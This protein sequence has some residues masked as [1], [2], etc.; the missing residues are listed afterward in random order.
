MKFFTLKQLLQSW[1]VQIWGSVPI[2]ATI[3]YN[4]TWLDSL[5][6][7]QY[8]PLVYG[9]LATLGLVARAVK[10]PKIK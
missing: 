4:T 2:L 7:A 10:Q 6:P 5:V 3:D 8:K 9:A 1:S